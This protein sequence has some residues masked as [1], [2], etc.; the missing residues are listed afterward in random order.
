MEAVQSKAL[1]SHKGSAPSPHLGPDQNWR[2]ADVSTQLV[3]L[4]EQLLT[5]LLIYT[6]LDVSFKFQDDATPFSSTLPSC[7]D[8]T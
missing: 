5:H 8:G 1:S 6:R 4:L 7:S 3:K 2:R